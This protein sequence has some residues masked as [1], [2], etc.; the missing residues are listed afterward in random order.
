MINGAR[1]RLVRELKGMTQDDLATQVGV[2]QSAIA[3]AES[4]TTP[5]SEELVEKIAYKTNFPVSFFR[6]EDILDFPLGSLLF[7]AH[8]A[9][10]AGERAEA[11]RYGHVIFE[12][13]ED[14]RRKLSQIPVR[15]PRLEVDDP[16][17]AAQITRSHF[18]LSPD[19]PIKNLITEIEKAG[20]FVFALP[21]A[22]ANF[23]AFSLWA[24]PEPLRPV[25]VIGGGKSGD[26]VRLSIA[27]ELG[28]LVLHQAVR[29]NLKEAES[30]A[31]KFAG[32]LLMPEIAMRHQM[33]APVTLTRLADL[34][35]KWRVSIQALIVRAHEL[36]IVSDRQ[37]RYLFE[38]IAIRGWRKREPGEIP[39]ERPRAVRKMA[40]IQYGDP[41]DY[42]RLGADSDLAPAF[43][44]EVIE[45]HAEKANSVA[46]SK[47]STDRKP[48][49]KRL[50]LLKK[51]PQ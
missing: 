6:R 51:P 4:G 41:V 8:S 39:V 12:M 42:E 29:G 18:G 7:R 16:M 9:L 10:T 1:I 28:H 25:M 38:Q 35:P 40:E 22:L 15:L 30:A 45:A 2:V 31:N 5:V 26:R 47:S 24:G 49:V 34:K 27:H 11:H 21:I 36:G 48:S 43:V 44:R 20:V 23:D 33:P 19:T 37:Y 32:E 3:Q 17:R 13:V 14:M 50:V 46:I